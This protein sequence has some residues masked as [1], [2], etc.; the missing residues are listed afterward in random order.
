MTGVS[1]MA[2]RPSPLHTPLSAGRGAAFHPLERQQGDPLERQQGDDRNSHGKNQT[3]TNRQPIPR[4][5]RPLQGP[6]EKSEG[7]EYY[8]GFY[9]CMGRLPL[10]YPNILCQIEVMLQDIGE[11]W[12][13][14]ILRMRLWHHGLSWKMAAKIS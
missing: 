11:N 9:P 4:A 13:Y 6:I 7:P 14:K 12:T 2:K 8:R 5:E 10:F 3:R 1:P